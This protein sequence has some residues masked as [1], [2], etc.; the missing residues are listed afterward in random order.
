MGKLALLPTPAPKL[1]P[2]SRQLQG[3]Q[4]AQ[5]D[6]VV[7]AGIVK[8]HSARNE[9]RSEG[10]QP[11]L[12]RPLAWRGA[13]G[14]PRPKA[15]VQHLGTRPLRADVLLAQGPAGGGCGKPAHSA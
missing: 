9:G 2:W 12:D 15:E 10:L 3:G 1:P 14:S 7:D 8:D 13:V 4:L 11:D 5:Q 6:V